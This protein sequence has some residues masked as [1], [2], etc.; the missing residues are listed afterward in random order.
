MNDDGNGNGDQAREKGDWCIIATLVCL[1]A[2]FMMLGIVID[3]HLG[4]VAVKVALG[5]GA[6]ALLLLTIVAYAAATYFYDM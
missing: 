3:P 6:L 4:T 5:I 1:P 2:G